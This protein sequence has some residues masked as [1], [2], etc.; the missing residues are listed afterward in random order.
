MIDRPP[1]PAAPKSDH[2]SDRPCHSK[3]AGQTHCLQ[4]LER[5]TTT[6]DVTKLCSNVKTSGSKE[7]Y[8]PSETALGRDGPWRGSSGN[9][10]T[11]LT[12]RFEPGRDTAH[13]YPRIVCVYAGRR[14]GPIRFSGLWVPNW[15]S[16]SCD[17][18]IFV[19]QSPEPIATSDAKLGR[20]R[21][22]WKRLERRCLGQLHRAIPHPLS[23]LRPSESR[24][25]S[26]QM[27]GLLR[28]S[29]V[30]RNHFSSLCGTARAP[31]ASIQLCRRRSDYTSRRMI[32]RC[33]SWTT[34]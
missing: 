22:G 8:V 20:R 16:T 17:L 29:T 1:P 13:T 2:R 5:A 18:G 4:S 21:R 6:V 34:A 23:S 15:S 33:R 14:H 28:F 7:P 31:F 3:V 10:R 27:T 24:A 26:R 19:Y 12:W 32:T 25:L 30:L 9:G 11:E